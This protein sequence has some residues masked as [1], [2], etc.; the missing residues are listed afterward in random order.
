MA[1][2]EIT[3]PKWWYPVL[4]QQAIMRCK[5][6][7]KSLSQE[8]IEKNV[9]T[10]ANE[11]FESMTGLNSD[12]N[13]NPAIKMK[14]NPHPQTS[15]D[16][17]L[18]TAPFLL[19]P[20][21]LFMAAVKGDEE[22]YKFLERA[23][24]RI[25]TTLANHYLMTNLNVLRAREKNIKSGNS[26]F[27]NVKY[28]IEGGTPDERE[29]N[30]RADV[31][32]YYKFLV[33]SIIGHVITNIFTVKASEMNQFMRKAEIVHAPIGS[34]KGTATRQ[35]FTKWAVQKIQNFEKDKNKEKYSGLSLMQYLSKCV[36]ESKQKKL[37]G[38]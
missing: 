25:A 31:Y 32:K 30:R 7:G 13:T 20:K 37:S 23:Y 11:A 28:T 19:G 14:N 29:W 4:K 16:I 38:Y 6:E 10:L 18:L 15:T 24:K 27:E 36:E 21:G 1:K 33:L 5:R 8:N 17:M 2:E 26:P 3:A 34:L 9:Q 22:E 35:N 12:L